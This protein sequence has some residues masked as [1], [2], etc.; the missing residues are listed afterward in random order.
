MTNPYFNFHEKS[1]Q[2]TDL[3]QGMTNEII[4]IFGA[5]FKFLPRTFQNKDLVLGEDPISYFDTTHDVTLYIE[6]YEMYQN[7]GDLFAKFGFQVDD[8]ITLIAHQETFLK[9]ATKAPEISDLIYYPTGNAIFEITHVEDEIGFYQFGQQMTYK[10][11]CKLYNYSGEEMTTG[12]SDIDALNGINDINTSDESGE[13]END[14]D[15]L[16][17]FDED[18]IFG[19]L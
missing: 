19:N 13:I 18:N 17:N 8:Q 5:D 3:Y 16:F 7:H 15:D 6:N 11:T 12:I 4:Q 9:E 14:A 2:E 10:L 1:G